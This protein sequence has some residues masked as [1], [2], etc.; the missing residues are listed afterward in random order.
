MK[1]FWSVVNEVV[2][3]TSDKERFPVEAFC[4]PESSDTSPSVE[5]V[6]NSFN[7]F[8]ASVG[9]RLVGA[10]HPSDPAVVDDVGH[11]A[12]TEFDFCLVSRYDIFNIVAGLRGSSSSGWDNIPTKLI[13]DNI[14]AMRLKLPKSFPFISQMLN[15]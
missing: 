5:N 4:D 6:C 12:S 14:Q 9:P 13:K 3:R 2:G 1:K 10:L 11:A 15:Q 7:N 8:F